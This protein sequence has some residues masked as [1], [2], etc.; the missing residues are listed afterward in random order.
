M[1]LCAIAKIDSG[2]RDRLVELAKLTQAFGIPPRNVH[3]HITLATYT[4]DDEDGFMSSCK[5]VLSGYEK[6]SVCYDK[7]EV[8]NPSTIIVAVPRKEGAI[9]AVQKE[10]SR[11]WA[12]DLDK[13]TQEDVWQPHTT[14]VVNPQADFNAIAEAMQGIFEPFSARVNEI[15]FSRV[16]EDGYEVVDCVELR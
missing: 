16:Y 14:L 9:A 5:A 8:W 4:G 3:G 15:E 10:I 7:I 6:F 12:A 2:S 11:G 13:W 1:M